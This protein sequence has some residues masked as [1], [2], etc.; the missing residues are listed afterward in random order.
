ME[1]LFL[2]SIINELE[3][4][5][6][7]ELIFIFGALLE[8]MKLLDGKT[9]II[10]GASRGMR[11]GIALKF[12]EQGAV[13]TFTYNLSSEEKAKALETELSAFGITAKGFKSDASNF[14]SA[15]KLVDDVM[16]TFGSIDVV[17]N[18]AGITK[19]IIY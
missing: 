3:N 11:K 13:F 14:D 10:T 8:N 17:V 7:G 12:A 1:G 16:G 5:K 19:E 2:F 6:R 9:V 4:R 18:N 15:Q